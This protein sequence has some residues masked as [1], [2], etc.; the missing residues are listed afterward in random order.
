L[1]DTSRFHESALLVRPDSGGQ[2]L[3]AVIGIMFV[4]QLRVLFELFLCLVEICPV[5]R[6]EVHTFGRLPAER[7]VIVFREC[8]AGR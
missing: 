6:N 7:A 3:N 8:E 2:N 4:W 5:R 1:N